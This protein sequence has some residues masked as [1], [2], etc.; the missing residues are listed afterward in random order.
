VFNKTGI[1]SLLSKLNRLFN[2][3]WLMNIRTQNR[4]QRLPQ[5]SLVSLQGDL[6]ARLSRFA[7]QSFFLV[8]WGVLSPLMLK[9]PLDDLRWLVPSHFFWCDC[10]KLFLHWLCYYWDYDR[11]KTFGVGHTTMGRIVIWVRSLS[12]AFV[13][14]FLRTRP[15][16]A[17]RKASLE[18]FPKQFDGITLIVDGKHTLLEF[19][20][21]TARLRYLAEHG[22]LGPTDYFSF[23]LKKS[24]LNTQVA[25]AADL[26]IEWV[27][28][29]LPAGRWN[30][31]RQFKENLDKFKA[32]LDPQDMIC[33]DGGYQGI[34]K[35]LPA[36]LPHRKPKHGQLT[37]AELTEN[38]RIG[39]FRG[40]IERRFGQL[41]A[42]FQFLKVHYR[43]GEETFNLVFKL[44]C[45]LLN[46]ELLGTREENL[47]LDAVSNHKCFRFGL[48][49][50]D[51]ESLESSSDAEEPHEE[52]LHGTRWS[53][54]QSQ[55]IQ[56]D[57]DQ[58]TQQDA[59]Q[60]EEMPDESG[61]SPMIYLPSTDVYL[62]NVVSEE[63]EAALRK[64]EILLTGNTNLEEPVQPGLIMRMIR[65]DPRFNIVS[66]PRDA[67]PVQLLKLLEGNTLKSFL[68]SNNI[69]ACWKK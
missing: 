18:F 47:D 50:F 39:E 69:R 51:D 19:C 14:K 17:R 62:G 56:Q 43:H 4:I 36:C 15:F 64:I 67:S 41:V 52:R 10:C 3:P 5:E 27:S 60:D 16:E 61:E 20:Q 24:A 49:N 12:K 59:D 54:S 35:D 34:N 25:I 53:F 2:T 22:V 44:A 40:D 32:I 28:N 13:T 63:S 23:K 45:S 33:F 37:N 8:V 55:S 9:K 38:D 31:I 29:S 57:T 21:K 11:Y 68:T 46:A 66:I 48:F 42:K 6:D 26:Y 1:L 7:Q 30:D 65:E 58:S